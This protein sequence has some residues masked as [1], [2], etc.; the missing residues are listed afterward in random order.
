M[1][2]D[3]TWVGVQQEQGVLPALLFHVQRHQALRMKSQRSGWG[4]VMSDVRCRAIVHGACKPSRRGNA[5]KQTR[6]SSS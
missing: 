6:K 3:A 5:R 4:H 1:A 2:L